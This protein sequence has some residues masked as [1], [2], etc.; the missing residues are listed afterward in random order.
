[1]ITKEP[2]PQDIQNWIEKNHNSM[3]V[4]DGWDKR[5]WSMPYD[6][7]V[8]FLRDRFNTTLSEVEYYLCML[9]LTK[10]ID[11]KA[12]HVA[13]KQ[14]PQYTWLC[15]HWQKK[16]AQNRYQK[17]QNTYQNFTVKGVRN[18]GHYPN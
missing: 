6:E 14:S 10:N 11:K 7:I 16:N 17:T 12:L 2:M 1:M 3:A 13:F 8:E 4:F 18:H 15:Y 9:Y 5:L